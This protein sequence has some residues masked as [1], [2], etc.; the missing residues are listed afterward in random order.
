MSQPPFPPPG[1][2]QPWGGDPYGQQPQQGGWGQQPP[3]GQ[4]NPYGQPGQYGQPPYGQPPR[5][6]KNTVIALS[7]GA[8]VVVTAV[9]VALVVFLGG[10]DDDGPVAAAPTVTLSLPPLPSIPSIPLPGSS[11]D[12]GGGDGYGDIVDGTPTSPDGLGDDPQLDEYAQACFDGSV[13]GCLSLYGASP[14]DSEYE[15]YAES[16]GGRVEWTEQSSVFDC[17]S[18]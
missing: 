14:V 10:G 11:S 1:G 17:F 9:V 5:N 3:Y 8:V 7:I 13:E 2:Q 18:Y 15:R 16:C 12:G 4:Q 6:N